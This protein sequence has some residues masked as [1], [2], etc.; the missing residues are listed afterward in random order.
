MSAAST[1]PTPPSLHGDVVR[2]LKPCPLFRGFTDTGLQIIGSI[3]QL[4]TLP[5]GTPLFVEH[6]IGESLYVIAEGRIR[7]AIRG[8]SGEEVFLARVTEPASL[9]EAA[10]LRPGP[11]QC[12][13]TAESTTTV[14]EI[15]RRDVAMLQRSK[16]QACLK[17]MM[18][19]VDLVG[20]RLRDAD[21][22]MR[23]FLA[24][25]RGG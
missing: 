25:R 4:K 1:P 12:S 18:G 16:P 10:L 14:I 21:Q 2:W 23:R 9:G 20:E 13:A 5:A 3:A 6:M 7:L 11:R 17:L 24:W 15:L 8:P 19:V 22:D